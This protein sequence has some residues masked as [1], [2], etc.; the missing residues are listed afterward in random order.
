MK[1]RIFATTALPYANGSFHIGH[2]MEYIQ[3]DIWVRFQRMQGHEVHFVCADDAH[4]APIMLKAEAEGITPEQ[5]VARIGAERKEYLDGFHIAFDNWHSTHSPENT[6]LSQDIYRKLKA[7]GLVYAKP[8]EQFYDPVKDMFLADR[9][10]K[11]DCPKCGAKDQYGDACEACGSVYAPTD[12]KN[13]YS[14][15]SGATP[16]LRTS[17]HYFFKLSDPE[18]VKFL[19]RWLAG[20]ETKGVVPVQPQVANKAKEW[21]EGSG[22]KALGDWDISRDAPYF[23][24][25]IPDAPGKYFYV[26]LDAPIGYLASFKNYC[27]RQGIDFEQFLADPET[28]QIHFIGKDIIYFHTLFWPAMLHFAGTFYKVPDNIFVHGF[29][30]VSGEK[31][32]KSRGTG[33]SPLRYLEIGM[34]PEWLRYYIAAKLNASVEDIDFNPDDFMARVNSDLIGKYVN[35]ASRIAPFLDKFF[36]NK[37]PPIRM[38]NLGGVPVTADTAGLTVAVEQSRAI[39]KYLEEREFGKAIRAIMEVADA[40]NKE[41]DGFKPWAL[42]KDANN[43]PI[44]KDQLGQIC[45]SSIAGFRLLTLFLKPI[46]PQLAEE[47]ERY[48]NCGSLSWGQ[49]D[50]PVDISTFL[51]AGHSFKQFESLMTRVNS[52]QLDGLFDIEKEPAKVTSS[53]PHPTSPAKAGVA[54]SPQPGPLARS[55]SSPPGGEGENGGAPQITIDDFAKIDLRVAKITMAEHVEGADRLLKLTLDVGSLGPRQVFAGIKSAYDPATLVGR[56]TVVV[57]N[58]APRKM[59]FGMSEGMVLAASGDAPGIFLLS[60]D[61]GAQPGM[62]VK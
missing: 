17:E 38:G 16:V 40:I 44:A 28:E 34:N 24:I 13:P 50:L 46:L 43:S 31:M 60:P 54:P 53:T 6:E 18:C 52:K 19:R 45:A 37:M 23:G 36:D 62:K 22:D 25:P 58:L 56:L 27:A 48:L 15:L 49:A 57:A 20:E 1:R 26:W 42:A 14:T 59:K 47:A 8:V 4:G 33:I 61:S 39:R 2:I 51:P 3:A 7:A 41:I 9:Y 12:L 32:S 11:G 29:I 10:L 35:I 30:N 21:L 5:L 55:A